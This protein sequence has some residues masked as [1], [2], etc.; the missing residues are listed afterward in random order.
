VCGRN[1][2]PYLV[3]ASPAPE[4]LTASV[5]FT[6]SVIPRVLPKLAFALACTD[7]LAKEVGSFMSLNSE[8]RR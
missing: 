3:T 6:L 4:L 8:F 7:G 1:I 2:T 5:V